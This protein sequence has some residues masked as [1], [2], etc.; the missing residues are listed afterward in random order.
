VK[1]F[2]LAAG[3]GT[4]L[5]EHTH[6]KPKALVSLAGKPLLQHAIERLKSFGI[7]DITINVFHFAEQVISFIE[8]NQ[9]FGVNIRVSDERD[10]L[11]DTGGGLKKASS[12]LKG[13]E[14]ILIYNVDVISNLDLNLLLNYHLQHNALATLVVRPRETSRYL[15]FDPNLQ[16]AGWKNFGNGE[17]R[18]SRPGSFENARP[19]A[20]SGI[21]IIQPKMLE[22]ITEEG[23]FPIIDLYLRLAKNHAIKAFVDNSTIWMDVGKPDQLRAAEMLFRLKD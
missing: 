6:D 5:Q 8:K 19:L 17:S 9:S 15:M 18:I 23:K 4:R 2:L 10:Q 13:N 22:L 7:S 1:A 21:H 12:L 14:P 11:L 3:L 16:L 20:F